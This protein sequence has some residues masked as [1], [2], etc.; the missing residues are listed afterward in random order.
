MVTSE[1]GERVDHT[2][3]VGR[4]RRGANELQLGG[5]KKDLK[6]SLRSMTTRNGK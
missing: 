4:W 5:S 3:L 6:L 1:E 2:A